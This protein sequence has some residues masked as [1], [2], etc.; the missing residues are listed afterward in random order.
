MTDT[1]WLSNHPC[2]EDQKEDFNRLVGIT[3]LIELGKEGKKKWGNVSPKMDMKTVKQLAADVFDM[4][5][6]NEVRNVV[7]MGELS[8]CLAIIDICIRKGV[9]VYTPTTER[10]S[11][12][13]V[14]SDGSTK[15]TNI[16]R[17][18]AFRCL[19]KA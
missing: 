8:L 16:F 10:C 3:N 13:T 5:A 6:T 12:E 19:H 2:N 18:C 9:S 1:L 14:L 15:K 4:S 11:K 7:I 17:H